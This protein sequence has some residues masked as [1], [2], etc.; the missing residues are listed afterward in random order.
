VSVAGARSER[1]TTR[2]WSPRSTKKLLEGRATVRPPK[3][4]KAGVCT[5]AF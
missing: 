5:P 3:K 4:Q 2:R 1:A